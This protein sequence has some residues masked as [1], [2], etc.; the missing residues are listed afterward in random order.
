MPKPHKIYVNGKDVNME[1]DIEKYQYLID[2][3]KERGDT[4]TAVCV[5]ALNDIMVEL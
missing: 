3:M 2:L 1:I 5:D 4:V